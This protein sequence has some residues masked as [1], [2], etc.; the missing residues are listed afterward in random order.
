M[1]AHVWTFSH[2]EWHLRT[3]A[4]V[5]SSSRL[6]LTA[7]VCLPCDVQTRSAPRSG[8]SPIFIKSQWG[9]QAPSSW[10]AYALGEG[11]HNHCLSLEEICLQATSPTTFAA[12]VIQMS[13]VTV[14][15]AC[16]AGTR[17]G[18]LAREM[19]L[20]RLICSFGR[21]PLVESLPSLL[22][23]RSA[24]GFCSSSSSHARTQSESVLAGATTR[25]LRVAR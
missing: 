5:L 6:T 1:V 16:A 19:R 21:I 18:R 20:R 15:V 3:C 11:G 2:V 12:L 8:C 13:H 17:T 25:C 4:C 7:L 10:P 14:C 23:W 9:K 22:G 24:F